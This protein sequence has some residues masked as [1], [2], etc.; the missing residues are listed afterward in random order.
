ML[1]NGHLFWGTFVGT[2]K[3]RQISEGS[4]FLQGLWSNVRVHYVRLTV[5]PP[6]CEGFRSKSFGFLTNIVFIP[7]TVCYLSSEPVYEVIIQTFSITTAFY[8]DKRFVSGF[9][10]FRIVR[11]VTK[12]LM[13]MSCSVGVDKLINFRLI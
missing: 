11:E 4:S 7:D 9:I 1:S 10:V 2:K 5:F 13:M 8:S 3:L 12:M 6:P